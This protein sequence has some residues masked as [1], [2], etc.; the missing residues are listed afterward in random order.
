MGNAAYARDLFLGEG[1]PA[2]GLTAHH[3]LDERELAGGDPCQGAGLDGTR[4][5]GLHARSFHPGSVAA[6]LGGAEAERTEAD[7]TPVPYTAPMNDLV[8]IGLGEL[9]KV[10]AQSALGAGVRVTPIRRQ[11]DMAQRLRGL[12]PESPLLV[13]VGEEA[14]L[15]V[16]DALP[17]ERRDAVILLQNELWPTVW[18]SRAMEPSVVLPWA[19]QKPGLSRLVV[20][21]SPVFGRQSAL[22]CTLCAGAGIPSEPLRDELALM[23]ALADKYAFILTINALGAWRDDVLGAFLQSASARVEALCREASA[24]SA[25]LTGAPIDASRCLSRTLEAMAAMASVSARGRTAKVRVARALAHAH[26]LG[27]AVPTLE[28]CAA[29]RP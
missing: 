16:L 12:S 25:V 19:L 3:A 8:V 28:A 14:L 5:N 15:P 27:V 21:T 22:L 11:D 9:G 23:Q 24:L 4:S 18:R 13:A 26:D 1:P 17:A 29:G 6:G 20:G 2:S 7:G 10:F